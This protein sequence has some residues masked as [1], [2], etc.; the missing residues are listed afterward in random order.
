MDFILC[1]V[2]FGHVDMCHYLHVLVNEVHIPSHASKVK[3]VQ[4]S[5]YF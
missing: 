1:E 4:I 2:T 5:E 3:C